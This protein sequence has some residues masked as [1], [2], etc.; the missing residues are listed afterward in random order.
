MASN[1]YFSL[2][3]NFKYLNPIQ[4]GGK[5][6]QYIDVKNLFL[7]VKLRDDV[8]ANATSFSGYSILDGERPDTV[9]E[10]LYNNPNYD[11]VVLVTANITNVTDQW[12]LSSKVLYEISEEKYGTSLNDVHHYETKEIKNSEG[13]LILPKG[14]VVDSN[15]TIPNPDNPLLTINPT[16]AVSNWLIETRKNDEKRA[17]Q[18]LR[19]EYLSTLLNDIRDLLTYKNSSQFTFENGKIAFNNLI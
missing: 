15:F 19:Q 3:P 14:K 13:K 18:V 6:D 2:L 5:R 10:K 12:P 4:E 16:V 17:I 1:S 9:A 8:I 11:W 7:R